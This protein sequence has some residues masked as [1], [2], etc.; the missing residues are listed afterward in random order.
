MEASNHPGVKMAEAEICFTLTH[1][2]T[3]MFE[4]RYRY[5]PGTEC[6]KVPGEVESVT[7]HK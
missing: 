4:A 5:D 2:F 1:R 7:W 6:F 3:L